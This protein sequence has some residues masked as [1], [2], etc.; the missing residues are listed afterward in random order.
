MPTRIENRRPYPSEV[1]SAY[2]ISSGDNP[3]RFSR[4]IC[5]YDTWPMGIV[6]ANG[7]RQCEG[8]SSTCC[9]GADAPCEVWIPIG[10]DGT[11][12]DLETPD[13]P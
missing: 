7:N 8:I 2:R 4:W 9:N 5:L 11:P 6:W 12:L 3:H 1:D 13:K 10:P